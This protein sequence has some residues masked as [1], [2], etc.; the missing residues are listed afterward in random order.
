VELKASYKKIKISNK[1]YSLICPTIIFDLGAVKDKSFGILPALENKRNS[2]RLQSFRFFIP[3]YFGIT[4]LFVLPST[5][6]L[7]LKKN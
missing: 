4:L 1:A 2:Q 7:F 5:W 6:S 3:A